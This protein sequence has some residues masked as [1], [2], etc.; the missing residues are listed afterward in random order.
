[1][2]DSDE[3]SGAPKSF[4]NQDD[5]G[6][7]PRLASLEGKISSLRDRKSEIRPENRYINKGQ[8]HVL[9]LAFRI[10]VEVVSALAVGLGIGWLLDQWLDTRPWFMLAFLLMGGFAGMLNVYRVAK[11]FGLA[12]GYQGEEAAKDKT[13][14]DDH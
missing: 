6:T 13:K 4:K 7:D 9:G 5:T 3:S 8:N 1:M 12:V 14:T 11:G 10:S 2:S